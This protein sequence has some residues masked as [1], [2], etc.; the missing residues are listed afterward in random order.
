[1]T[2]TM[3][4]LVRR[5]PTVGTVLVALCL[6]LTSLPVSAPAGATNPSPQATISIYLDC[7]GGIAL[8]FPASSGSCSSGN[9]TGVY[10]G[11][12]QVPLANLTSDFYLAAATGGIKV[13]FSLTDSTSGKLLLSGVGYGAMAGGTCSSPTLIVPTRFTPTS[14]V[15]GSGDKLVASLN[16]TFTGTGTPTFCSGG[17]DATLVSFKTEVLTGTS[18]PLLTSLLVPGQP[19]QTT[20]GS[21]EGVAENYTNTGSLPIAPFVQGVV[22]NQAGSTIDILSTSI[23]LQPGETVTAF[24]TFKQY[25]SGSYTV[26]IFAITSS[27]VPISTSAVAQ[28]SV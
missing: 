5:L 22:K 18:Q 13:T 7:P 20:L 8:A 4:P 1:V 26:T 17:S 19:V 15:I 16:T 24:L 23:T 14:N 12:A 2:Q 11:I 28:V 27:Y 25:P 10:N 21:F 6:L 9:Y 3:S